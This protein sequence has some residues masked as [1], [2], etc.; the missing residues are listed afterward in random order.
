MHR[1]IVIFATILLL[2]SPTFAGTR[3]SVTINISHSGDDH[4]SATIGGRVLDPKDENALKTIL[5]PYDLRKVEVHL[6]G[7]IDTPYR[8]I[9][10]VIYALQRAGVAKIGFI[11]E[12]EPTH[13]KGTH[14]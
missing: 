11:S 14:P 12:P 3:Q 5:A 2:D 7:D 9:G 1:L 6:I 13:D 10:G 8:C 4:C